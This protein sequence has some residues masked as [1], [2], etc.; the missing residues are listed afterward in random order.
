MEEWRRSLWRRILEE[1]RRIEA[2]MSRME[3]EFFR[4]MREAEER[5]GCITPLYNIYESGDE[6][7]L[8]A[9]LPGASKDEI[10]LT[11]G[12]DYLRIEAPCRSPLR[13]E[14]GRRYVLHIKLPVKIDPE[15]VRARYKE[16]VLEVVAKKRVAGFRVKVE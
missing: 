13:R 2:E 4:L 9:D 3:D 12:E 8:T 11:A 16:G 1:F 10:D 7:I 6:I 15:T 14:A 5:R